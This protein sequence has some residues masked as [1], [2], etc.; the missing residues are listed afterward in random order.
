MGLVCPPPPFISP[1]FP[2]YLPPSPFFFISFLLSLCLVVFTPSPL[3]FPFLSF[4]LLFNLLSP[5]IFQLPFS[6]CLNFLFFPIIFSLPLTF[7]GHSLFLPFLCLWPSLSSESPSF[8]HSSFPNLPSPFTI[9]L[10][11]NPLPF[12]PPT[13]YNPPFSLSSELSFSSHSLPQP[14][15]LTPRTFHSPPLPPPSSPLLFLPP[16]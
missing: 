9:F 4:S 5:L 10:S 14:P 7:S 15:F 12:L 11:P 16:T 2:T 6:S 1:F 8:F 3:L 13:L